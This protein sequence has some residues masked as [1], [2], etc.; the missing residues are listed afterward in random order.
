MTHLGYVN[1]GS[2]LACATSLP[3]LSREDILSSVV[4]AQMSSSTKYSALKDFSEWNERYAQVLRFC[5]YD[6]SIR[7]G[8]KE[9]SSSSS[10]YVSIG[11]LANAKLSSLLSP[12]EMAML[13]SLLRQASALGAE[14]PAL[15]ILTRHS[16]ELAQ[17][18]LDGEMPVN[19]IRVHIGI[20]SEPATLKMVTINLATCDAIESNFF[21]QEFALGNIRGGVSTQYFVARLDEDYAEFKRETVLRILEGRGD[22]E[23]ARLPE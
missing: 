13:E 7:L 17:A 15:K 8:D 19:R 5:L 4:Y 16:V 6:F 14:S 21:N 23:I 2:V 1:A 20:V 11:G 10:Q 3:T 9:S 12:A 18:T 22:G